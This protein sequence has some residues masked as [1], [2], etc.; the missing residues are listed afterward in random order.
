VGRLVARRPS[1]K[2]RTPKTRRPTEALWNP[3]EDDPPE[4]RR[5]SQ[6]LQARAVR[7]RLAALPPERGV[8]FVTCLSSR[9]MTASE[10]A[11][12]TD[13][14]T[15]EDSHATAD[16]FGDVPRVTESGAE[17]AGGTE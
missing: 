12:R 1:D 3:I 9:D 10:E 7:R 2:G 5:D 11:S 15:G 6:G 17:S 8:T 16:G 14:V 13:S 4:R